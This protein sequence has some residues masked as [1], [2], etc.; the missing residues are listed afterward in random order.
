VTTAAGAD[1]WR[2]L[3]VLVEPPTPDRSAVAEALNLGP[4]P[5][6]ADHTELFFFQLH[7]YASVYL[8]PE[9]MLGGEARDRIAGFWRAVGRTPPGEP[10]HLAY[11]L[12]LYASLAEETGGAHDAPSRSAL[13]LHAREALLREHLT[14]WLPPYLLK[15]EEVAG[16]F[17]RAWGALLGRIL[18]EEARRFGPSD[19]LPRHLAEA[20]GLLDDGGDDD[21]ASRLLTPVRSG[22]VI[23]RADLARAARDRGLPLRI[24]ERRYALKEMLSAAS[25]DALAWLT[26]E[27][28][29]WADRHARW[30]EVGGASA[31]F[32]R[33]R[34]EASVEALER[35]TRG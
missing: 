17:Y 29:E 16:P 27:A 18:V 2:A 13:A 26:D 3:A 9:G 15:L 1:L 28:R 7:P 4:L 19:E 6:V 34:A 11:L 22:L 20:P 12:A 10:D 35:L 32:W 25:E 21:L 33:T 31:R 24:G 30:E 14:C 23:T 8:G 5:D